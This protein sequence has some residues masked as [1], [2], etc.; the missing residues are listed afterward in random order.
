MEGLVGL[1]PQSLWHSPPEKAGASVAAA[2]VQSLWEFDTG[3]PSLWHSR[4]L[5]GRRGPRHG[6]ICP[7]LPIVLPAPLTG[8]DGS[9]DGSPCRE[10]LLRSASN[11]QELAGVPAE[12]QAFGDLER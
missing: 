5:R 3:L 2:F 12:S 9:H 10:A 6:R 8:L 1:S 11:N 7:S 4:P